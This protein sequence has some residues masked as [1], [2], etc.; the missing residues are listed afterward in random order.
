MKKY[1][2]GILKIED[3][4]CMEEPRDVLEEVERVVLLMLP[5]FDFASI[6]RVFRDIILLFCGEYC[7]YKKCDI[8]YHDLKHTTDCFM[9]M[10]RLIHGASLRGIRMD[11]RHVELGLIAS[12]MHDTGYIR[13]EEDAWG[14]GAKY[15][16]THVERSIT[17]MG[18]YLEEK[19]FAREDFLLCRGCLECTG[20]DTK[21][22]EIRFHS[23][24]HEVLGKMLG[25]ADLLGQMADRTYVERLPFLYRE[26]VEGGVTGFENELDLLRKTAAFWAFTRE[27]FAVELSSV[28]Q[29]MRLHFLAR[30]GTDRDLY[31]EA[32]ER[33]IVHVAHLV[34]NHPADYAKYLK[35][36]GLINLLEAEVDEGDS[37]R[38]KNPR[39][40]W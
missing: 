3:L 39:S 5:A 14:T 21:I 31:R 28:D 32:I 16:L 8:Q 20:L 26:F 4:V 38:P 33:N 37:P 34:E 22:S 9:A 13:L 29:F 7:G 30:W 24:E 27:R 18:K 12:L 35:R 19:G 6:R 17:F 15:T 11:E 40:S 10:C 1:G 2:H 23:Y 36:R 25:T